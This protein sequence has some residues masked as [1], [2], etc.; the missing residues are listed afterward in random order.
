[1][2]P[3]GQ[4]IGQLWIE[5]Q[6]L[7]ETE[8][9]I[10]EPMRGTGIIRVQRVIL[11]LED[12]HCNKLLDAYNIVLVSAD[13]CHYPIPRPLQSLGLGCLECYVESLP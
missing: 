12:E 10:G 2:L 11:L 1:M 6:L 8:Y 4:G 7:C 9:F 13:G 5:E 3:V